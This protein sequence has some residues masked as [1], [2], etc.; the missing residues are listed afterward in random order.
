MKKMTPPFFQ[1]VCVLLSLAPG[2]LS[3]GEGEQADW[4]MKTTITVGDVRTRI[5]GP[6]RWTLSGIDYQGHVMASEE[7]A[8]G[9]VFTIRDV[10]HLGTAHFLDVPGRPGEVEK[11]DVTS[12]RFFV[13]GVAV[14]DFSPVM[15]LEGKSFRMERTSKIRGGNLESSVLVQDD[16]LIES[17]RVNIVEPVDLVKAHCVMYAWTPE[18]TVYLLGN[19]DGVQR[20]GTFL[21]E[22]TT[23]AEVVKDVNWSA[24]F[25]PKAGRGAVFVL[26][27]IPDDDSD[28]LIV[29]DSPGLYRKI[30]SYSLIDRVL[31]AGWEGAYESVVGFFSA[32]ESDW[33]A[34]ALRRVAEVKASGGRR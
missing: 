21:K 34:E 32:T 24:V 13:D 17:V 26:L 19:D 7:S 12:L 23:V 22:G 14:T 15:D 11:E 4:P 18:A 16:V 8:Y 28:Q 33:E 5:D 25:D 3:A 31:P 2:L 27:K 6:K 30:A 1:T 10:G 9:T 29:I 20:K